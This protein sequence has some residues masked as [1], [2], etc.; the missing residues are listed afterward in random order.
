M[1]VNDQS[2]AA[3]EAAIRSRNSHRCAMGGPQSQGERYREHKDFCS[4]P[5]LNHDFLVIFHIE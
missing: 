1:A 3:A 4:C 5:E 2:R